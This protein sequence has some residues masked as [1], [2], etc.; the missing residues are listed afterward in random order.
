MNDLK[1][2]VYYMV[3]VFLIALTLLVTVR[4]VG[5]VPTCDETLNLCAE[6]EARCQDLNVA[7]KRLVTEQDN[8]IVK[9]TKQRN[10]ALEMVKP[11][12]SM[13]WYVWT[14]M[15]IAGGVILTRGIR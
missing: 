10:E 9:V 13:P 3:A 1:A 15:G 6:S 12:P 2:Q 8:L 11:D 7:Q 5:E 4:G 14:V